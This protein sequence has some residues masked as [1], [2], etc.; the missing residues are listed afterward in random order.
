VSGNGTGIQAATL[1]KIRALTLSGNDVG[2]VAV[3]ADQHGRALVYDTSV[4]TGNR[5]GVLADRFVKMVNSSITANTEIGI[6]A[7][8]GDDCPHKGLATIKA[9]T[10][11]GNG[12]DAGC[13]TT[14]VCADLATCTTAPHV[15]GGATCDHS[16]VIGSG[17]PGSDWDVCALD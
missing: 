9:G 5:I 11:T 14:V 10:V 6:R 16:Y 7:G 13:G 12:T 1:V 4:I 3:N 17:I 15:A 2:I 8:L